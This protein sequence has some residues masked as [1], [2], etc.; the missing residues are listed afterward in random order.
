MIGGRRPLPGRKPAD[1]RVRVDRPHSPYFRYTGPGQLVA[2]EAASR[3]V[4][5]A[6]RALFRYPRRDLRATPG[7]RGRDRR[8]AAQEEGPRH[9][10]LGRDLVERLRDRGDPQ[11]PHR[12]RRGR[13]PGLL[14]RD[15]DRDRGPAGRGLP[16]I[17]PGLPGLPQRGRRLRGRPDQPVAAPGAGRGGS[18]AHR[19]RDDRGGI[20][21]LGDRADAV[22]RSGGLR[23][24]DRGGLRVDRA[25]HGRQPARAAGVR[26]HLRHP[27][28]P[29]PGPR[30]ADGRRRAGPHPH[31]HGEPGPPARRLRDPSR[32]VHGVPAAQ[33]I[34][35]W[36]GR[37]DRRRGHR[38]RRARLQA[39][40]GEECG[41]H[42]HDHGDP[43]GR[44]VHRHHRRR[45]GLRDPATAPG[46]PS[47]VALVAISVFGDGSRARARVRDQHRAHPLPGRQHELQRLPPAGR[48]PRRGRLHAPPVL[49]PGRPAGVL[50]GHRPP[51]RGRVRPPVDLR[52]RHPRPDPAVLGRRIRLLHVVADRDGQALGRGAGTGLALARR[53]QRLRSGPDRGRLPRR[54][55]GQVRRRRLPGGD[56][57]PDPGRR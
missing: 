10:Q 19:L 15:L 36:L 52:R 7:Q 2:K 50:V 56:P 31:R 30:P 46:G 16:V 4:T 24:P 57:H 35:R 49:V 23:R 34:R 48:D 8:T 40:R 53:G 33:G 27:D 14:G 45:P 20:D 55:V 12:R 25:D 9:L 54:G 39:A 43:A 18:A 3:P 21:R 17:P 42:A 11:G 5:P 29:L 13:R 1:R 22:D 6:G 26:Q 37:P 41:Q 38:Q 32:G 51:G 28:L 47:V 44:A